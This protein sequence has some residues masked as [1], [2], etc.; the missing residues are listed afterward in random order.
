MKFIYL[1]QLDKVPKS[2]EAPMYYYLGPV[3]IMLESKML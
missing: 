1:G 3:N 2:E